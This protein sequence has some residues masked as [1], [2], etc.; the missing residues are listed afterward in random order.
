MSKGRIWA[1]FVLACAIALLPVAAAAQI[2]PINECTGI[3]CQACHLVDLIQNII[4][5][6]IG[7]SIPIAMALFAYA[8]VL[9]FTSAANGENINKAKGIFRSVLIGFII[10][11]GAYLMVET[12]LHAVL[13]PSYFDGWNSISCVDDSERPTDKD[14]GDLLQEVLPGVFGTPSGGVDTGPVGGAAYTDDEARG[15]LNGSIQVKSGA[16]LQ[17]IQK[18][19]I[20][21]VNNLQIACGC[22]IVITEGTGGSHA[23]GTYSHANGYKVD[24]RSDSSAADLNSFITS[25]PSAGTRSDGA[26]MYKDASGNVYALESDHWDVQVTRVG[27]VKTGN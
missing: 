14:I 27:P 6:A 26:A 13:K 9:Y 25:L 18:I 24:L 22:Q 5:F 21:Q 19:T 17:G 7:L 12:V 11:L 23:G 1:P 10:T 4:N 15:N 16:S 3:D 2:V 8:G 20:D